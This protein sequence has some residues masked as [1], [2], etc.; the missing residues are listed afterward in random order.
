MR[1]MASLLVALAIVLV[2]AC[3]D[4][5]TPDERFF[6]IIQDEQSYLETLEA[7]TEDERSAIGRY[8]M[9]LST[10]EL[11]AEMSAN[12]EWDVCQAGILVERQKIADLKTD[13]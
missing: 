8:S 3:G 13:E 11:G 9:N 4:S 10:F 12:M 7:G 2:V 5:E 6:Q 1:R